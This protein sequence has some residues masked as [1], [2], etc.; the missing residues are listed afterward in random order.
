MTIAK[1]VKAVYHKLVF[2]SNKM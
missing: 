2:D 1:K